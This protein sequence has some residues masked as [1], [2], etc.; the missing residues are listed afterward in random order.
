MSFSSDPGSGPASTHSLGHGSPPGSGPAS[1]H[2]PC[3]GSSPAP[4][5][6]CD[7][8]SFSAAWN[9][10]VCSALAPVRYLATHSC[11]AP[12]PDLALRSSAALSHCLET[13]LQSRTGHGFSKRTHLFLDDRCK[14]HQSHLAKEIVR[15][16]KSAMQIMVPLAHAGMLSMR[17]GASKR[18]H[19]LSIEF[20]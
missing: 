13:G 7:L 19:G 14:R 5:H 2:C 1:T 20:D 4:G 10:A 12:V 9:T 6:G 18:V 16:V 3:H 11:L 15:T 17:I 8:T